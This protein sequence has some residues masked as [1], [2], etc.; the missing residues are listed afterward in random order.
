LASYSFNTAVMGKT[1]CNS[2][3]ESSEKQLLHATQN[4]KVEKK[5]EC[6]W[7]FLM[8]RAT[9]MLEAQ[10]E[11]ITW[12]AF[13][14]SEQNSQKDE[15]VQYIEEMLQESQKTATDFKAQVQKIKW[16]AFLLSEQ[17][18]QK[19]E[20]VQYL[21]EMLQESQKT[22]T[23]F[24]L[25]NSSHHKEDDIHMT[26]SVSCQTEETTY[27]VGPVKEEVRVEKPNQTLLLTECVEKRKKARQ[28]V[29][30]TA[31][32]R[33]EYSENIPLTVKKTRTGCICPWCLKTESSSRYSRHTRYCKVRLS[34]RNTCCDCGGLKVTH[35]NYSEEV[36]IC[37]LCEIPILKENWNKH[38]MKCGM[39]S[40]Q[41]HCTCETVAQ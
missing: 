29:V 38:S 14:L 41:F 4:G 34:I 27:L 7:C 20:Y 24:M 10:V 16:K 40:S 15:Y 13:L 21:E 37:N 28:N 33:V 5:K 12:K 9:F 39:K 8:K 22:A 18:R 25:A 26:G 3:S 6:G 35:S 30:T 19:D 17:N 36:V 11:K 31:C 1:Q 23:D 2:N 32:D